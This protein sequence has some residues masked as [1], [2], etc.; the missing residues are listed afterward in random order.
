[1]DGDPPGRAE[2]GAAIGHGLLQLERPPADEAEGGANGGGAVDRALP[3][4]P[5]GVAVVEGDPPLL[6]VQAHPQAGGQGHGQ[7]GGG[8]PRVAGATARRRGQ[9]DLAHAHRQEGEG[10]RG[11]RV[12]LGDAVVAAVGVVAGEGGGE[13]D[14]KREG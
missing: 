9:E 14:E 11:L 12:V 13:R 2:L 7:A 1:M 3:Q 8:V 6:Q 4:G 5:E 10:G